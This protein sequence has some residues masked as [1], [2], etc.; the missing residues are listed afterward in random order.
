MERWCHFSVGKGKGRA[1]VGG[2][3]MKVRFGDRVRE[4]SN[5]RTGRRGKHTHT[6]SSI[7]EKDERG[8]AD[9]GV[10]EELVS[11]G[12]FFQTINAM[13]KQKSSSSWI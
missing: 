10:S 1:T 3:R 12:F 7:R 11:R 4:L 13:Q 8:L 2:E 5:P 9:R 6:T